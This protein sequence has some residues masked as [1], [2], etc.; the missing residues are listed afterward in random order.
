L[1]DTTMLDALRRAAGTWLAKLLL[2]ILVLSFAVWGVAD[3][4]RGY[5]RGTVARVGSAAIA[6]EEFQQAYQ[7]ELDQVSRQFGRRLTPEQARMF[8]LESRVLSRL[9][10]TAAIDNQAKD[11]GLAISDQAIAEAIRSDPAFKTPDGK[12]SRPLFDQVLRQSGMSERRFLIERT[13]EEVREQLTDSLTANT[14]VPQLVIDRVHAWR[15]EKRSFELITLDPEKSVK[16]AD[17][18]DAKLKAYYDANKTQFMTPEYRKVAMLSISRDDLK[19]GIVIA[20]DEVKALYEQDKEKFNIPEKRRIYQLAFPDK[21]AAEKAL[22]E[23][24]KAKT[25]LEGA[26]ALGFK[27]TDID[28]GTITRREIIDPKIADAAFSLKKDE[29][30]KAVEGQFTTVLLRATEIETG[31][32]K[33]LD[34]VKG[35]VR[36]GLASERAAREIQTVLTK[37]DEQRGAGKT[38]KQAGDDLKLTFKEIEA[39]DRQAKA[40]DGKPVLEGA[41]AAK[42]ANAMFAAAI[43]VE[44]EPV[45]TTGGGIVWFDVLGSTAAK[46][47]PFDDI[48]ADVT[49]RLINTERQQEIVKLAEQLVDRVK[50]GATLDTIAKE[51]G[52]KVDLILPTTRSTSPQ[53]MAASAVQQGFALPKGSTYSAVSSNNQSRS[54]VRVTDVQAAAPPTKEQIDRLKAELTRGAQTDVVNTYVTALQNRYGTTI[55]EPVIRQV[56]GLD[57]TN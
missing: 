48:K 45:E 21:A 47:K 56:L 28:L 38:L 18:D 37:V 17:P 11:L 6:P 9:V 12:F 5:D 7:N 31:K 54:V 23:L 42:I 43:G 26:T 30:S 14:A 2:G 8:G 55:N 57:R 20:D 46:E 34:D 22:A 52:L 4:F 25:F 50:G 32:I 1:D 3:V 24:A 41:D 44:A 27:E 33:T 39:I 36:D 16:I 51:L 15:E 49:T 35:E 10:G 13:R 29:T 40:P 19:K 53:G